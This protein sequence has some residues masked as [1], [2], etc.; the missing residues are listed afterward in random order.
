MLNI[1][2]R[3]NTIIEEFSKIDNWED[4]YKKVITLGKALDALEENDCVEKFRIKGCQSQVWLKPS[5]K[6]GL[7]SF[8]AASDAILVQ[9]I[10]ALL[11]KVYSDSTPEEIMTQ[12]GDFLKQIGINE[13]LSMNRTNGLASM[14]KQIQM[15][16]MVFKS[17][18][19]K[20]INNADNF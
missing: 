9:G 8:K 15:Y 1:S 5:Y 14:L 6:N 20:G 10:I 19:D 3:A 13:H 17:L 4:K 11:I 12:R 18:K 2:D 16:G 7:V